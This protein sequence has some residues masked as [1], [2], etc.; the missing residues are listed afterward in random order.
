MNLIDAHCHLNTSSEA[1]MKLALER[2]AAFVSIN[3]DIPFFESLDRQEAVVLELKH[4]FPEQVRYIGSFGSAGFGTAR[5][6]GQA[7]DQIKKRLSNGATAIK[8]WKNF[9]MAIQNE[10]GSYVMADDERLDPIYDFLAHQKVP[11]IAHLGE[12]KNCWLPLEQMTVD[13]DR[14][15]FSKH[16]E[17]HMYLNPEVPNHEAQIAAR[18]NILEKHRG[19]VFVGA[20]LGSMEWNLDEVSKRLD[21]YPHFHVDL[22]ER[23]CHVQLQSM[24]DRERV[25]QFFI[26][27]QDRIIYGSDV[28]DDGTKPEMEFAERFQE[29][30]DFHVAYFTTSDK[31]TAP[32]FQG[33]FMGLDLP[34]EVS[35]KILVDNA[36]RMY[37]F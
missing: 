32:E 36:K 2:G 17:Y 37:K 16:P 15:Y 30:W 13:S 5:W 3:T 18:D 26:K 35:E 6:Q 20:H 11:L 19:L 33:E 34:K 23:I 1:K 25:R 21:K 12:P 22:A 28:I 27:Y 7:L 10:D 29:L 9:G 31:M 14:E 4:Q 8:I 24:S